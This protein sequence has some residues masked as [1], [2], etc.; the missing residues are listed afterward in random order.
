VRGL[1]QN[2]V[3]ATKRVIP[4]LEP[5]LNSRFRAYRGWLFF[6]EATKP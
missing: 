3:E 2:P 5:E 1:G 4:E 6:Q